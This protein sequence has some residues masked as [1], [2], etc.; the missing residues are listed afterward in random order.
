[1][2]DALLVIL[3]IIGILALYWVLFGQWKYNKMMRESEE[4]LLLKESQ[5]KETLEKLKTKKPKSKHEGKSPR[6]AK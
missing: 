5:V 1:M 3:S 2:N 6:K 4:K